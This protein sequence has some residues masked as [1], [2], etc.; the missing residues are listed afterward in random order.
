MVNTVNFSNRLNWIVVGVS[1]GPDSMALLDMLSKKKYNIVVVHVNYGLRDDAHIDQTLVEAYCQNKGIVCIVYHAP[2]LSTGNFQKN[3]RDYRFNAFKEVYD[4]YGAVSLWLGHHKDDNLETILFELLSHREPRTL[5]ISQYSKVN[6]MLVNR[7]LLKLTKEELIEYCQKNEIEFAIDKTNA[8]PLYT[9]NIIRQKLET[10]SDEDKELLIDYQKLYKK[11]KQALYRK[12]KSFIRVNKEQ[13][14]I[15]DYSKED[16]SV[17]LSILREFMDSHKLNTSKV[18]K[19]HLMDLDSR[20]LSQVHQQIKLTDNKLF[21]IEYGVV[22]LLEN[23]DYDYEIIVH[24][25]K[26]VG[27]EHFR[28]ST[29]SGTGLYVR[30]SDFPL[31]IRNVRAG[32]TIN[33]RFGTKKLN[34]FFIDRKILSKDR[35]V[36][37][38]IENKGGDVICV[39]ELGCDVDHYNEVY[40]LYLQRKVA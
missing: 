18:T 27:N 3:A 10:M 21:I 13:I 37:P 35:L 33:M 39:A 12:T 22:Y 24:T 28:L 8:E 9:R 1:G 5:G 20:V 30:E 31:T 19:K 16:L 32:D 26:T 36:W 15:S 7:P 34:R 4:G 6:G 14:K 38:V 11:R 40:N 23:R 25:I 17:R 2:D 29:R